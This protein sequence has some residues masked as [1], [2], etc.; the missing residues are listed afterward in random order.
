M[1]TVKNVC[2]I[3]KLNWSGF[4][5]QPFILVLLFLSRLK[6]CLLYIIFSPWKYLYTLIVTSQFSF[7]QTK[8]TERPVLFLPEGSKSS[9][10][11]RSLQWD[12]SDSSNVF[13]M[14]QVYSQLP[15]YILCTSTKVSRVFPDLHRC[16]IL[17][18]PNSLWHYLVLLRRINIRNCLKALWD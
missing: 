15:V 18:A 11:H 5:F 2:L 6:S 10:H 4:N 12:F 3:S 9:F 17:T 14:G 8:K 7:W 13:S 1:L 16:N